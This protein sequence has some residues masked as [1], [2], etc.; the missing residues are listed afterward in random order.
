MPTLKERMIFISHAWKYEEHY[1]KLVEWFDEEPYFSWKNCSVPSHD[2]CEETTKKGL[3][4]CLTRQI[5]P[6]NVV[7][8]LGGMYAAHSEWIDYEMDEAV[9]MGKS[10]IGVRPWGQERMPQ[11]LQDIAD[12]IVGWNRSSIIQAARDLT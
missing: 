1:W 9:R 11:K 5:R 6:A 8:I 3:K 7:I 2:A 12:K 4:E 10:I